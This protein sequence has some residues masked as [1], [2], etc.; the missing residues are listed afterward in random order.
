[1]RQP[2]R[3]EYRYRVDEIVWQIAADVGKT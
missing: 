2:P 3:R 1:M